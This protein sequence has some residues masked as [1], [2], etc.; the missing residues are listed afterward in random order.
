MGA[1][2]QAKDPE[3]VLIVARVITRYLRSDEPVKIAIYPHAWKMAKA[4]LCPQAVTDEH[5]RTRW[6]ERARIIQRLELAGLD[7]ELRIVDKE[8]WALA[9]QQ[10]NETLPKPRF[11]EKKQQRDI[12]LGASAPEPEQVFRIIG[13]RLPNGQKQ[14]AATFDLTLRKR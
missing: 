3:D 6:E 10:L 9:Y 13:T 14:P 1:N 12:A 11:D 2:I 8:R 7:S 5:R 4:L